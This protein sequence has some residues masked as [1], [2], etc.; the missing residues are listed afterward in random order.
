MPQ[1]R[2]RLPQHA[3]EIPWPELRRQATS[4]FL[5]LQAGWTALE[6]HERREVARLVRKSRGRPRNLT[7]GEARDL[8]RLAGKAATAARRAGRAPRGGS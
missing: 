3:R 1:P 8:G 7:K 4:V 6:E 2:S 5:A